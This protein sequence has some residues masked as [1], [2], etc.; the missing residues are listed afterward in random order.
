MAASK[1]DGIELSKYQ[2]I[3]EQSRSRA[4]QLQE[5]KG[6]PAAGID[7]DALSSVVRILIEDIQRDN[8]VLMKEAEALL[9]LIDEFDS[10]ING[11]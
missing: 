5:L 7:V 6:L 1:M 3:A 10:I 4:K 11:Q 8:H 2:K 9:K